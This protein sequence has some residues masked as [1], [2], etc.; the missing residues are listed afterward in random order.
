MI[1]PIFT[2]RVSKVSTIFIVLLIA[3]TGGGLYLRERNTTPKLNGLDISDNLVPNVDAPGW[4]GVGLSRLNFTGDAVIVLVTKEYGIS[5]PAEIPINAGEGLVAMT[6]VVEE[7]VN[8]YCEENGLRYRFDFVPFPVLGTEEAVVEATHVF[9]DLGV[10]LVIGYDV[11]LHC[12]AALDAIRDL[13]MFYVSPGTKTSWVTDAID[14]F[15]GL[16]PD[17]PEAELIPKIIEGKG[18][19]ALVVLQ[20]DWAISRDRHGDFWEG[21]YTEISWNFE[22]AGGVIHERIL[23][24]QPEV[25]SSS[26]DENPDF[27]EYCLLADEAVKE[28]IDEHGRDNVGVLCLGFG[29]IYSILYQGRALEHL[30]SVPWFATEGANHIRCF[31]EAGPYAKRVGLYAPMEITWHEDRLAELEDR[32][33][34][35]VVTSEEGF[36]YDLETYNAVMYDAC[37]LMAL[38]VVEADSSNP[39]MVEAAFQ[40]VAEGFDGINGVYALDEA[41]DK[42]S[43]KVAVGKVIET[44]EAPYWTH[45]MERCGIYDAGTGELTLLDSFHEGP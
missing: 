16:R 7:D 19:D 5:E 2:R 6:E 27:T 15:Y 44:P 1:E 45:D 32:V 28:A 35:I 42:L 34:E 9:R 18:V 29:E 43:F 14:G 41:G 8:A 3:A 30:E 13:D 24:P 37:W 10:Q 11:S 22:Q 33:M 25:I 12:T 39:G 36:T 26:M 38:S 17:I 23:Y 40:D 20:N 21:Y 31:D 4:M